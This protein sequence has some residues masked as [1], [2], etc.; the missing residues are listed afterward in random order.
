MEAGVGSRLGRTLGEPSPE[1]VS[2][3]SLVARR[4]RELGWTQTDLASETGL[5]RVTVSKIER[6]VVDPGVLTVLRLLRALDLAANELLSAEAQEQ[7]G[8]GRY[9]RPP[10]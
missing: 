7:D 6:G 2:F 3:G 9:S 10:R 4:R 5:N 8:Q 1:L